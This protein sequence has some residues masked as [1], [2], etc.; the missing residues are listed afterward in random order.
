MGERRLCLAGPF[1]L[2]IRSLSEVGRGRDEDDED[3]M[4]EVLCDGCGSGRA[5]G[6]GD[7]VFETLGRGEGAK[8]VEGFL[9]KDKSLTRAAC[10]GGVP[11][12]GRGPS[13][14]RRFFCKAVLLTPSSRSSSSRDGF[15]RFMPTLTGVSL[16]PAS[17]FSFSGTGAFFDIRIVDATG[18]RSWLD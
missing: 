2:G 10:S 8:S 18:F 14:V 5:E 16:P 7:G 9:G 4:A 1:V 11:V 3:V 6:I 15:F 13:C 17:S 12:A